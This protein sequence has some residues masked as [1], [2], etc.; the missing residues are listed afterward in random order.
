MTRS[1]LPWLPA[2]IRVTAAAVFVA[3]GIGLVVPGPQTGGL[4]PLTGAAVIACG[5]AIGAVTLT[6]RIGR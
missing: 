6:G 3:V 2:A 1:Y 4:A 5:L